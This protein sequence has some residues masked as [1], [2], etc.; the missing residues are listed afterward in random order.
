MA[1]VARARAAKEALEARATT[2]EIDEADAGDEDWAA[3]EDEEAATEG[4]ARARRRA[5]CSW[6]SRD[7][8][9]KERRRRRRRRRKKEKASSSLRIR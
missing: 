1:L 7:I 2:D 4:N 9:R 5:A 8:G 6:R 3:G